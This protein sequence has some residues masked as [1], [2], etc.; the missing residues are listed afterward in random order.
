MRGGSIPPEGRMKEKIL[1][2]MLMFSMSHVSL[3]YDKEYAN[4][5][6][7]SLIG[8]KRMMKKWIK[9]KLKENGSKRN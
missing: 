9:T 5:M 8:R 2:V 7:A 4:R 6:F 1:I 3:S